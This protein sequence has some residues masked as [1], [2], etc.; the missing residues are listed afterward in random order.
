MAEIRGRREQSEPDGPG[1]RFLWGAL[2]DGAKTRTPGFPRAGPWAALSSISGGPE[3][4]PSE[5][6]PPLRSGEYG[7][8][9]HVPRY[10]AESMAVG[11]RP[12]LRSGK[13][14]PRR[15]P[16]WA[17]ERV[18]MASTQPQISREN[19]SLAAAAASRTSC[20]ERVA[21]S[22]TPAAAL[23]TR[24]KPRTSMPQ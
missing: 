22:T 5:T 17:A 7:R 23:D 12:P 13:Y 10:A 2:S 3:M 15:R 24:E 18:Y 1:K 9:R 4:D 6:R 16:R 20:S 14:G 21:P 11:G 8:R 19:R